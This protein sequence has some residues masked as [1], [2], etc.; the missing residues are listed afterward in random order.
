MENNHVGIFL[1]QEFVANRVLWQA[2]GYSNDDLKRPIIGIANSFSDMVPGHTMFR[3]IAEHVKYGVYR[4]GG[5]PAEFGVIACCDGVAT[6]HFGNNYTLPSRDNIADSVEIMANAHKL[7]GLVLLASCD[8]IVPGML[9]AAARLD[10]PCILVPGG[11]ML[12][13]G[14]FKDREKT[15]T[16]TPMEAVGK[17]SAGELTA[18]EVE[19]LIHITG[20]SC[21]ACQFMGTANSMCCLSE[22]L[23]M[24]LPGGALIP[25]VYN[26]RLRSALQ[27]GEKI[28]ELV[29]RGVTVRDI[30][31]RKAIENVVMTMMAIGGSTNT[32]IHTCAIA[33]ELGLDPK[34]IMEAFDRYSDKIP[35]IAKINP[36]THTYDALDLYHA[37]GVPEVLKVIRDSLHTDCLTVTG[38]TLGENLD[39]FHNPYTTD[40]DLIRPLDNPHSALGGLAIMR[41]N[42]APDTGVAKPA[43]IHESVRTFKGKAICFDSED[44]CVAAVNEKRVKPGHV[45]VIRYE[46]PK[47]GPGMK[48]MF[49]PLK[50]L[51]GQGLSRTTALI[52]DGRFSGTNNGCFVGHISPEAAAGGPIALVKDGDE[53]T[54]D[55]NKKEITLHVSDEELRERRENWRYTP[56]ANI[57]GYLKRYA[58]LVTSADQGGVLKAVSA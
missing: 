30:L 46:G 20:A 49:K 12:P 35:L 8:K 13:G 41:G 14:R 53:I 34:D 38:Q 18:D 16:T 10:I 2:S 31:N 57:K 51:N 50:L 25:A 24:T 39:G 45:V 54:V 23:G 33:H 42:L 36:A 47:G 6:G 11:C 28:V 44:E 15:D 9:M 4:A 52:T 29:Q 56:P 58:A 48:E 37:G 17:M 7:D 40:G 32:V 26:D 5:T 19:Q 27:S 22:A 43:A 21:G 55:V 1:N 3:K